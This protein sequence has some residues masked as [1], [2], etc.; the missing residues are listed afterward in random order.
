MSGIAIETEFQLLNARLS[1]IADNLELA[2]EN[3]WS[4]I[5]EYMGYTWDG[6]IDYPG[7]FALHN[8]DNELDQ[9]AK[10]RALSSRPEV[11][12]EIDSRI[13]EI[14][15]IEMLELQLG[16]EQNLE[17]EA[18]ETAPGGMPTDMAQPTDGCPIE[19]QDIAANLANRQTAIDLANYGPLNPALPNTVFWA[20]KADMWNTD[21]TTAKTSRCANCAA[22]NQTTRILNCIDTGLAAGGSGT[23]DAWATIDAG[24]LGYCEAWDF[25]CAS[26]RTCDAWISGGPIVD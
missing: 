15:D 14:L 25:K 16:T 1:S 3:V 11:Q 7:N 26:A 12:S 5:Y 20:A 4:I 21:V 23:A 24:D 22:F 17:G 6:T 18:P 8:T 9:F 19:T 13:A 2:E 10:I